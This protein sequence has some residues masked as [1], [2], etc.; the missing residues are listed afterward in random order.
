M[1]FSVVLYIHHN[2]SIQTLT[3]LNLRYNKIGDEGVQYLAEELKKNKVRHIVF[4][5]S[6]YSSLY[7]KTDPHHSQY[8]W[9]RN[10]DRRNS[11]RGTSVKN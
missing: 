4:Y 6:M 3:S 5:S 8:T 2:I 9:Q 7:F 11:I 10:W 1:L